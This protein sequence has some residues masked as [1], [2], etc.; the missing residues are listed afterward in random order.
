[1]KL[2]LRFFQIMTEA[3]KINPGL[4]NSR[5]GAEFADVPHKRFKSQSLVQGRY[6]LE[7]MH[8][9]PGSEKDTHRQK[10][11]EHVPKTTLVE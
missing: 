5:G 3:R 10:G 8:G 1:M 7:R 9:S 2:S 4:G 6:I 11:E